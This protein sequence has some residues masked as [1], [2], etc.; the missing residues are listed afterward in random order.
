MM[1]ILFPTSISWA[2]DN[3]KGEYQTNNYVILSKLT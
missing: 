2:H 1:R 3:K